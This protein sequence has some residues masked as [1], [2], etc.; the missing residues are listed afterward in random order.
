MCKELS[1]LR[2]KYCITEVPNVL[3]NKEGIEHYTTA[4]L[5]KINYK[6]SR[7]NTNCTDNKNW[8][9]W[10]VWKV[11][12]GARGSHRFHV[13]APVLLLMFMTKW[14]L[15]HRHHDLKKNPSK[16]QKPSP[17]ME[18]PE[19][20]NAGG[21]AHPYARVEHQWDPSCSWAD[22][23]RWRTIAASHA[24]TPSCPLTKGQDPDRALRTRSVPVVD[25]WPLLSDEWLTTGV[26]LT[27]GLVRRCRLRP[28]LCC[29][30]W[31]T[32]A[33]GLQ[34]W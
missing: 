11:C 7:D 5:W 30:R 18:D 22:P 6:H 28:S 23:S 4:G 26:G 9:N 15:C 31:R 13:V 34:P 17:S 19:H 24:P 12:G 16:N 32:G 8:K 10:E 33:K 1:M 2:K 14:S 3:L 27:L 25:G 21:D 29:C 20:N